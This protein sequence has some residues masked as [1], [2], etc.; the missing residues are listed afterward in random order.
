MKGSF[1]K[2]NETFQAIFKPL[3]T[4]CDVTINRKFC[5]INVKFSGRPNSSSHAK[6]KAEEQCIQLFCSSRACYYSKIVLCILSLSLSLFRYLEWQCATLLRC[7]CIQGVV[8]QIFS[9]LLPCFLCFAE[10][11]K[12][13]FITLAPGKTHNTTLLT[14]VNQCS[15]F[16]IAVKLFLCNFHSIDYHFSFTDTM[17]ETS[18]ETSSSQEINYKEDLF[19]WTVEGIGI[20]IIGLIGVFGNSCSMVLFSQQK[21]HRIFH[22]L[23]LLLSVFDLVSL[24]FVAP[25]SNVLLSPSSQ[26]QSQKNDKRLEQNCKSL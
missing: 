1:E 9:C 2:N 17:N 14:L 13:Q 24:F 20:L 7:Y 10:C 23:L 3:C 22:H 11:K 18:N 4:L 6:K 25:F 15:I 26:W 19:C 16:Y 5:T 21:V 8:Q 12:S